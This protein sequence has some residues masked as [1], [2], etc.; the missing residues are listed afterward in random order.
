MSKENKKNLEIKQLH[1]EELSIDVLDS[2]SGGIFGNDVYDGITKVG[3]V[4]G[5]I[6]GNDVYDGITKIGTLR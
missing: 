6:F 1:T 3:T 4:R 2:I 5:G